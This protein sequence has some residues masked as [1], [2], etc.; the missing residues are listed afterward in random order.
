MQPPGNI[1]G[2]KHWVSDPN[3]GLNRLVFDFLAPSG[4]ENEKKA[5]ERSTIST[6]KK[7]FLIMFWFKFRIALRIKHKGNTNKPSDLGAVE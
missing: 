3:I 2:G 6:L 4:V 5:N 7:T 1:I